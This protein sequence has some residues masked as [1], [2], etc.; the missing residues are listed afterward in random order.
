MLGDIEELIQIRKLLADHPRGM[1][2]TDLSRDLGMHRTT[3]AKY[4][5]G[6]QMKGE[7]DLRIVSTAKVYHLTTRIPSSAIVAFT[8][9][10]YLL[11]TYRMVIS[12][13][14]NGICEI[15][16]LKEDPT[17]LQISDPK[18]SVLMQEAVTTR[19][20]RAIQGQKDNLDLTITIRGIVHWL[21]LSIIPA[22]C[23]DGRPGCAIIYRDET[24][25]RDAVNQAEICTRETESLASDQNEFIFRTRLDGVLTY[26][27]DAFCR[28]MKKK[29]DEL[30]GF[31]YDPVISHEDLERLGRLKSDLTQQNP[32]A[33]ITFKV[34]QQDGMIAWE[35]WQYRKIFTQAGIPGRIQAIG[36]D[37]SER[38]HLE[39]QLLIYHANF[40]EMITQRTR[41]MQ[42]ANQELMAEIAR[43]EKLE[44]E[45]LI[46][47]FVFDQA[48][49][50]ILLFDRTGAIYRA[51]ETA[52][53]LL[54]YTSEEI[55]RITVFDINPEISPDL[56]LEMWK[57][58][59]EEEEPFRV[60]SVHRRHDGK[61]IPVEISRKFITAGPLSLFCSIAREV[62]GSM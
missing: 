59:K 19:I 45:L 57:L 46:I 43:R 27:N 41:E 2:I 34:I 38:K 39:D 48:S 52:C 36:I 16:N 15:F 4:L 54:G 37:I 12:A 32:I 22:V 7:V 31:P 13:A 33:K 56:W 1:S 10:P 50:S 35:E 21:D 26:V 51:N 28:R 8:R 53:K 23:E 11:I 58:P 55:H 42:A 29:R 47:R 20:K 40:E 30:I 61:I 3:I 14:N 60:R 44:R 17:G 62:A 6:L 5:D 18:L 25:F 24:R 9:D 49:D